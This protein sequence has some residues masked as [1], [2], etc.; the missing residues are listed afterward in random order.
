[1]FKSALR[2]ILFNA[3]HYKQ[4]KSKY[5]IKGGR[6]KGIQIKLSR[7]NYL[8]KPAYKQGCDLVRLI[9]TKSD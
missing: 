3:F 1:M 4:G 7:A 6:T 5:I 2:S 8:R 9:V